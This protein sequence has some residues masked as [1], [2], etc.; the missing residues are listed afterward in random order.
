MNSGIEQAGGSP[1]IRVLHVPRHQIRQRPTERAERTAQ[2]ATVRSPAETPPPRR[3]PTALLPAADLGLRL[4]DTRERRGFTQVDLAQWVRIDRTILNKIEAGSRKVTAL[5]LSAIAD[6]LG[7]QMASF[8]AIRFPPS[9][10]IGPPRGRT[11]W[12]P[13]SMTC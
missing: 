5:E 7:V 4:R 6:S 9:C 2:P 11:P 10:P 8:S 3:E 13:T 12:T 1:G